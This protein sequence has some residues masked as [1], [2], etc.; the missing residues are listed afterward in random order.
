LIDGAARLLAREPFEDAPAAP[1]VELLRAAAAETLGARP[2][3]VG[4]VA[5]ARRFCA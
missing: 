1:V 4:D 2:P 3:V 5:L